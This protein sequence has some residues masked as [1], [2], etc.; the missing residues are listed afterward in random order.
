MPARA[1]MTALITARSLILRM[2]LQV[3]NKD[4][5]GRI[6][7]LYEQIQMPNGLTAEVHDLSREIAANTVRVEMIIRI[8]VALN[9]DD[10]AEPLHF[11]QT[12]TVFG[13]EIVFEHR[14]GQSF[15]SNDQKDVIFR[16]LLETFKQASLPYLSNPKFRTRFAASKYREILQNPYKYRIRQ[17]ERTES[18]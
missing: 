13:E 2:V 10:F 15:V 5:K 9:P 3:K 8:R 14:L 16:T 11:E 17:D 4:D 6:M 18:A 7:K 1:G 12:R